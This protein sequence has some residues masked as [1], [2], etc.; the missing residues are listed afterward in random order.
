MMQMRRIDPNRFHVATR[1]TSRHI[2]RQIALTVIGSHQPISRADLARRMRIRRGSAGLLV[3]ELLNERRIVEGTT[4]Q[5]ARGRKPTLLYI[6]TRKGSSVAV[7][8]RASRTFL[9]LADPMGRPQSDIL[10]MPTAR[11]PRRLVAAL[12]A[13]IGQ[14]LEAHAG[15]A[16]KC[17]GIGIVV[18]GMVDPGTSRVL[19]APTLGWRNVDLR[20]LLAAATGFPVLVENSG[21]ACALA[22]VW[23]ARNVSAP[24]GNLVFLSVSDGVGVGIVVN[25]ELLRGRHNIAGEFA[26]M[27]LSIDGPPCACGA[28]G[29]WE[30]YIS[31][32]ATLTRY[33]GRAPHVTGADEPP[34]TI[35]DLIARA[36]AGDGKAVAALQATARYLG[37]GLGGVVNIIDPDRIFIGGEITTAWDLVENTVRTALSERS[38]TPGAAGTDIV[39][40]SAD[41]HPR[42]RGAAML[43]AAPAFAAPVVA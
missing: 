4:G 38:L 10:S 21:R 29:C 18:P 15:D 12:A 23:E 42:L 11:D 34:F 22:Q 37:L 43:V 5:A 27:P 33:F 36:R 32:L 39:I 2:N 20:G 30:A 19:H 31:N 41:E 3:Q 17:E 1:G 35:D 40:V 16:G 8:I 25:G 13:R 24:V 26:H 7:D 9:M 28:I 14:L 6:N